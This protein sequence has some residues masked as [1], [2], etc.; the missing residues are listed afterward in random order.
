MRLRLLHLKLDRAIDWLRVG[1]HEFPEHLEHGQPFDDGRRSVQFGFGKLF[2]HRR[3]REPVGNVL[4]SGDADE[5]SDRW[6]RHTAS[7]H[8]RAD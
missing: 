3:E 1:L 4:G 5:L 7:I 8:D 6:P 2:G